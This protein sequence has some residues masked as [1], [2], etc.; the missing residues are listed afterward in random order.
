MRDLAWKIPF[1][2]GTA[3][4]VDKGLVYRFW[5]GRIPDRCNWCSWKKQTAFWVQLSSEEVCFV[6]VL[7]F[8]DVLCILAFE[9]MKTLATWA[10]LFQDNVL[11]ILTKPY[12]L[13]FS[14][15]FGFVEVDLWIINKIPLTQE[16]YFWVRAK[17][18]LVHYLPPRVVSSRCLGKSTKM[19][20]GK[21][22]CFPC[23]FFWIPESVN[24]FLS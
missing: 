20:K 24:F 17:M 5:R 6:L 16:Q 11:F 1:V 12:I 8:L 9:F 22:L 3:A 19:D 13:Y 10:W 14:N 2:L 7:V 18:R 21:W 4:V 23:F 15:Y